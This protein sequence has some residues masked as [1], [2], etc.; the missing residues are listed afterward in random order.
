MCL[1]I[2]LYS[3]F[4][5]SELCLIFILS[6]SNNFQS[7]ILL[8]MPPSSPSMEEFDL[9]IQKQTSLK[10]AKASLTRNNKNTLQNSGF[11]GNFEDEVV[12]FRNIHYYKNTKVQKQNETEA[13][14]FQTKVVDS[15]IF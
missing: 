5:Q 1:K 10:Q 15:V 12:C 14:K 11:K 7:G 9:D 6:K 4:G 3:L 8:K 2:A 13:K